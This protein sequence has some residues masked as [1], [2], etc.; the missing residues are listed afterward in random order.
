MLVS[1]PMR[2][3]VTRFGEISP[4]LPFLLFHEGFILYLAHYGNYFYFFTIWQIGIAENGQMLN[5]RS[6]HLVTLMIT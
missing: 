5:K 1:V 3:S 6:S 2:S 4:L